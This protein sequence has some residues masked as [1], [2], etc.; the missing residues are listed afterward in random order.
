MSRGEIL[1]GCGALIEVLKVGEVFE[2]LPAVES[3]REPF[4]IELRVES[5]SPRRAA[6][7]R[8]F[9]VSQLLCLL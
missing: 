6:A 1:G 2:V 5:A 3:A 4:G 8:R 9:M 7:R